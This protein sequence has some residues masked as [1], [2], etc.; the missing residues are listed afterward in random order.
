MPKNAVKGIQGRRL[1]EGDGKQDDLTPPSTPELLDLCMGYEDP[2]SPLKASPEDLRASP[3]MVKAFLDKLEEGEGPEPGERPDGLF[4]TLPKESHTPS[5]SDAHMKRPA[6]EESEDDVDNAGP[7]WKVARKVFAPAFSDSSDSSG[8]K[9]P[10]SVS[11]TDSAEP[12][13]AQ[14]PQPSTNS[15]SRE[16]L[17]FLSAFVETLKPSELPFAPL[18]SS[19]DAPHSSS[20]AGPGA[21]SAPLEDGDFV[22]PWVR[23]PSMKPGVTAPQFR[24]QLMNSLQPRSNHVYILANL[25]A[26]LRQ[27]M[28]EQ[29]DADKLREE[30][31][32][33][34][35]Y[36]IHRMTAPPKWDR[37]HDAVEVV[38]R[39]FV[40]FYMV[41]MTSRALGQAWQMEGWWKDFAKAIPTS[42]SYVQKREI[43]FPGVERSVNLAKRI[44]AAVDLYK[45][46]SA[47]SDDEVIHILWELFCSPRTSRKLKKRTWDFMRNEEQPPPPL[48]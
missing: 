41:H 23:V 6:T 39:R 4:D 29:S 48:T 47:P 15:G 28:L 46:G 21:H 40:V 34:A 32:L 25:R 12:G 37:P 33:L 19:D 31:E 27:P 3:L 45:D 1:A 9:Q 18:S 16:L 38:G 30:A 26:L 17:E 8:M 11:Q 35:N 20:T 22:H 43:W 5:T 13:D 44:S 36:A 24:P 42:C 14:F 7:S 2:W 10:S